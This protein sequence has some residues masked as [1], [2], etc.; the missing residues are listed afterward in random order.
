[1]CWSSSSPALPF[2]NAEVTVDFTVSYF[3]F[4]SV[5]KGSLYFFLKGNRTTYLPTL[6]QQVLVEKEKLYKLITSIFI[7][8]ISFFFHI[9]RAILGQLELLSGR[10]S[11]K[12]KEKSSLFNKISF[13]KKN[14]RCWQHKLC[15]W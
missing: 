10:L 1:M 9:S 2:P 3:I 14:F 15:M 8:H 5:V 7:V 11:I 12:V 6:Q 4:F 13:Q